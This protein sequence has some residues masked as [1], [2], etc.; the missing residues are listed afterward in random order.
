MIT[1]EKIKKQ[2]LNNE[3][4]LNE[5]I[6]ELSFGDFIEIMLNNKFLINTKTPKNY[7]KQ[8]IDYCKKNEVFFTEKDLILLSNNFDSNIHKYTNLLNTIQTFDEE[9]Y[10][11]QKEMIIGKFN[12]WLDKINDKDLSYKVLDYL[13]Y[14]VCDYCKE[15]PENS[16]NILL[17]TFHNLSVK[18]IEQ[19]SDIK[20][21]K[22][23]LIFH[24]DSLTEEESKII[25][26]GSLS[27]DIVKLLPIELLF[28][29]D[30]S[31]INRTIQIINHPSFNAIECE[32][33]EYF[34]AKNYK[35]L[36]SYNFENSTNPYEKKVFSELKDYL[37]KMNIGY[38]MI[39]NFINNTFLFTDDKQYQLKKLLE[40]TDFHKLYLD[41]NS[42]INSLY[43]N[44][45][46]SNEN[47]DCIIWC[48]N[49]N[50]LEI[51]L[52]NLDDWVKKD[53]MFKYDVISYLEKSSSNT[54]IQ[55]KFAKYKNLREITSLMI[56]KQSNAIKQKYDK[57]FTFNYSK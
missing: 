9:F 6:N 5:I 51:F 31:D 57:K 41:K 13:F 56:E 25:L 55:K 40:C 10:F 42:H 49:K 44:F 36:L 46:L 8:Y 48:D 15:N 2:L 20:A 28:K 52:E 53:E 22:Q 3:I 7:V 43:K 54:L 50:N 24:F 32:K 38:S 45:I 12:N 27:I 17:K 35:K 33:R 4:K 26:S 16:K 30:S 18:L 23:F 1:A 21:Y 47:L 14:L 19:T 11:N 37:N 29:I 34:L 39:D